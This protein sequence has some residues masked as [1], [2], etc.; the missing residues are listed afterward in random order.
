MLTNRTLTRIN[1]RPREVSRLTLLAGSG[2]ALI[3]AALLY[4]F[5][6][7]PSFAVLAVLSGGVLLVIL[8]YVTQKAKTTSSLSYMGNL[9][10]ETSARFSSVRGAL[11]AIRF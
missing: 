6:V 9:D 2:G 5:E 1:H 7:L 3:L 11:E 10:E 8:L 4:M